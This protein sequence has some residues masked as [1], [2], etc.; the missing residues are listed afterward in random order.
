MSKRLSIL[1]SLL[2]G[3]SLG[4]IPTLIHK[5]QAYQLT[6]FTEGLGCAPA[7]DAFMAETPTPEAKAFVCL[8]TG[9]VIVIL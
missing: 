6:E 9:T 5:Y 1:A 7:G 4:L 8:M 2:L 3:L